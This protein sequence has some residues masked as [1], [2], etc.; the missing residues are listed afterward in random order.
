MSQ[1]LTERI[2]SL[3]PQTQCTQCGYEGCA[4][5]ARAIA[6]DGANINRCPPGG[7]AGITALS[8]LLN[9][10]A[11]PLDPECGILKPNQVALIDETVC[12]GCAKCLPACPV[13]AI[14]GAS[15]YMHTVIAP[16][17]TGCGLCI[18]PCPVDC[19]TLFEDPRVPVLP[20]A[21][22]SRMRFHAHEA[23]YASRT[24][25]RELELAVREA[26]L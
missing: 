23:R 15:K 25:A 16:L 7:E 8:Q 3:L 4:P 19:I 5:Y 10:P 20:A 24:V 18:P 9:V 26:G 6:D 22:V 21:N 12:I 1:S 17:C 2:N 14:L 13:D 11:L